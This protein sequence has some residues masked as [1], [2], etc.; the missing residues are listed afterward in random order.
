MMKKMSIKMLVSV[1]LVFGMA[2]IVNAYV[3]SD[4]FNS[5]ADGTALSATTNWYSSGGG[6]PVVNGGTVSPSVDI[7]TMSGGPMQAA[8]K[9]KWTELK[10]GDSISLSMD[11]QAANNGTFN[12]DRLG[13]MNDFDSTTSDRI[14]G[15]QLEGHH[16]ESY[17]NRYNSNDGDRI[18]LAGGFTLTADA[19]YTFYVTITKLGDYQM[20]LD[21]RLT[22]VG[23]DL[24]GS[25]SLDTSTLEPSEQ[26]NWYYFTDDQTSDPLDGGLWPAFKNYNASTGAADNFSFEI[27]ADSR[28]AS[29]PNP[30]NNDTNVLVD[31]GEI[32]WKPGEFVEAQNGTHNVFFGTDETSVTNATIAEPLG[33]TLYQGLDVNSVALDR[34]EYGTTYYWRVDEVNIPSKPGTVTGLIWNFTT[35]LE[36]YPLEPAQ[37]VNI[38][39]SENPVYP[40]EQEPNMT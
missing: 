20:L 17:F 40:D 1:L 8:N 39:A 34:L 2:G 38:T 5:Y 33:T 37:I 31:L 28:M 23:G 16:I 21:T 22:T 6:S 13:M 18:E 26:P 25:G 4:D 10:V 30:K 29:N 12:D 36:G 27:I 9:V 14:F 3:V 11:F 35:E 19:W 7:A 24:V 32:S 15:A